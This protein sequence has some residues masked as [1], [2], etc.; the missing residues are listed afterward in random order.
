MPLIDV[1][2]NIQDAES[3]SRKRTLDEF[4]Q[5]EH[6]ELP[7]SNEPAAKLPC[8]PAADNNS[9]FF[10]FRLLLPSVRG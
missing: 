1:S 4:A 7:A 5:M 2:P 6:S 8:L 9:R 3:P 10:Y